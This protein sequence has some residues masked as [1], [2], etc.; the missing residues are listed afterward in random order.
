MDCETLLPNVTLL[1]WGLPFA[2]VYWI[3]RRKQVPGASISLGRIVLVLWFATF[4]VGIFLLFSGGSRL[5]GNYGDA[6][7]WPALA[8]ISVLLAAYGLLYRSLT[9]GP[10][11]K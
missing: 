10:G 5:E 9:A 6:I 8:T 2:A 4:P 1:F 3:R 11:P 7:C